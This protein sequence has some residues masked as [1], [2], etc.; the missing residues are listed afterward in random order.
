M[1]IRR[2]QENWALLWKQLAAGG[3]VLAKI[4][5]RIFSSKTRQSRRS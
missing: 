2:K 5:E 3:R 4:P 1:E